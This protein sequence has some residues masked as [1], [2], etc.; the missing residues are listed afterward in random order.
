MPKNNSPPP[1]F[2]G[3]R[4]ARVF[5]IRQYQDFAGDAALTVSIALPGAPGESVDWLDIL[6]RDGAAAVQTEVLGAI[7]FVPTEDEIRRQQN[8]VTRAERLRAVIENY[9][10][11]HMDN[12]RI[13]FRYTR[14]EEIWLHK[15][16]GAND[17]QET[18]EKSEIWTPIASPMGVPALLQM[19][20]EGD[21]YGLRVLVQDMSDKARAVDFE[22]GELAR[23][24]ASEIR[25]RL[26]AAGL[27]VE[28]HGEIICVQLLKA[29][30]PGTIITVV[31][32]PGW[33]RHPQ[34]SSPVFITPAG[35]AIGSPTGIPIELAAAMSLPDRVG[36][37]GTLDG[38]QAAVRAAVTAENCQH[39]T[40]GAC[41]G[42][43]GTIVDLLG[44]DTCGLNES[45]DTTLGKTTSQ[46]IAVSAWSSPKLSDGGLLKSMRTT[47]NAVEALARSSNGTILALDEIAHAD[48]K[49][50]AKL[51]YSLAG[52]VGKA[53]MRSD[54]SLR[55]PHTWHTFVLLSGEKALERKVQDDGGQWTGGMAVRFPDVDVTSVNSRVA[56]ETIET[57]K[58]IFV[59]YGHAG[60]AFVRALV[61]NGVHREPDPLRQRILTTA[62]MLAGSDAASP[63]VRAAMPFAITAIAGSLAQDF[64]ILPN[65]SDVAGAIG[66]AWGRFCNS[67][68]A[69]AIDPARQAIA[70][71]S[72]Y[73]AERWDVT[74]KNVKAEVRV[75]NREAVAWYDDNTIYLP[76][77]R[78]AEAAGG[79]VKEQRIA[80]ILDERGH[81]FR[82][83]GKN[84]IAI[85]YVPRIGHVD[86]YALRRSQF[87]RTDKDTDPDQLRV[88]AGDE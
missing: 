25:A 29:A 44:L 22:R 81:L 19:A 7:P 37:S 21:A 56:P 86:C 41:A 78:I 53:R 67:S 17:N 52:D 28:G 55:R 38:W 59:N 43:A 80:A 13:E 12:L 57:L 2:R 48:G 54:S 5:G 33:H 4:A 14:R 88:A 36:R 39:W 69:L 18:G 27:R 71:I 50:I 24:G 58:Q 84:R 3:E 68:D 76:T 60:P 9:P 26:F 61:D 8:R 82:R 11:Q 47:E 64:G 73:I 42:F 40:L 46:Q 10:L 20:N 70:R 45:G 75:N 63:R 83:G 30:K 6:L 16:E 31:S 32:R 15:F 66:W 51:I 1:S 23:L 85:R 79:V 74:I 62:R 34:L 72:Q 87:G 49:V 35:E 65:E 77:N